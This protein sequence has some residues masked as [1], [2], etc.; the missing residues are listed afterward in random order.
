MYINLNVN[1]MGD[2]IWRASFNNNDDN[3]LSLVLSVSLKEK[4]SVDCMI[5]DYFKVMSRVSVDFKQ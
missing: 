3:A 4:N 2:S 5:V 1:Q